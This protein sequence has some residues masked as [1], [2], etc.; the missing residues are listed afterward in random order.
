MTDKHFELLRQLEDGWNGEKS[1]KPYPYL[2]NVCSYIVSELEKNHN[3]IPPTVHPVINGFIDFNW[4]SIGLH[5][6]LEID[7]N[8]IHLSIHKIPKIAL[9]V[10]DIIMLDFE[11]KLEKGVEDKIVEVVVNEYFSKLNE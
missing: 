2:L 9:T 3:I 6:L 7:N 8:I 5:C 4:D 1:I 11:F 10:E